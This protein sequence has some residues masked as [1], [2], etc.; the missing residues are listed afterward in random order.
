M[1]AYMIFARHRRPTMLQEKPGLKTGELS[2]ELSAEWK[3]FSPVC[4]VFL[5]TDQLQS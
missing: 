2:K 5:N 1:N 4:P 3:A